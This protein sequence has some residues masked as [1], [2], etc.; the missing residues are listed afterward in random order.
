MK[1]YIYDFHC[2]NCAQVEYICD[3]VR[4]GDYCVPIMRGED[5]I[6]VDDDDHIRCDAYEPLQL[7]LL[8][9]EGEEVKT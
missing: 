3:A 1:R 5:P 8:Q 6:H 7:E 4:H 2:R 9:E